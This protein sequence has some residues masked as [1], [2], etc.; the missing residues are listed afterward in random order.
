[1]G[2]QQVDDS[3][4]AIVREH[5]DHEAVPAVRS[6]GL[7]DGERNLHRK[8]RGDGIQRQYTDGVWRRV[9]A[10]DFLRR[11]VGDVVGLFDS[12]LD[13]SE[14]FASFATSFRDAILSAPPLPPAAGSTKLL[15]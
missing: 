2:E 6:C 14:T 15:M 9:S 12:R 3:V 13:P 1:M 4:R 7:F 8:R 5:V 10:A 11:Q